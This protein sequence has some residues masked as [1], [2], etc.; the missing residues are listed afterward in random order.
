MAYIKEITRSSVARSTV[1][2]SKIY[3]HGFKTQTKIII[4]LVVENCN[5]IVK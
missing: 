5:N 4:P 3:Y 1:A 2:E